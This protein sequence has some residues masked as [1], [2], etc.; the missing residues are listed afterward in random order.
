MAIKIGKIFQTGMLLQRGMPVKI[1]GKGTPGEKIRVMIQGQQSETLA[2]NSGGWT[3][4]LPPLEG[5]F[6]ETMILQGEDSR[7]EIEDIAVGEV[8]VA[9]GQS[10][11]EFWMRY[12]KFY[13]EMLPFCENSN[14]RFYDMPKLAYEGQESDFDY[15]NAGI[16]RKASRENLEYFSA[17]G[18]YFARK[19]EKELSVPIGIVGCNWGGTKSL[20]WMQEKHARVIQKEQTADFEARLKGQSYEEFYRAA[21]KNPMN[22][23]GNSTWKPFNDFILPRTPSKEEINEFLQQNGAQWDMEAAKPQ[24]APG[25][26]YRYMVQKLAPYTVRAILWYQG[27]S[28]DE[29]NGTQENY[30]IALDTIKKDWREAWGNPGLPFFIVQLPGFTSWFCCSNQNFSVI[31]R[32][33]QK[34][35]EEDANAFLCSISDAGEEFDIHP[36]NKKIVGERLAL[37]A[38]KYLFEKDI[39][40]DAPALKEARREG[41]KITLTFRHAKGGLYVDGTT[42]NA[43]IIAEKGHEIDYIFAIFDNSIILELPEGAYGRLKVRLACTLWYRVNLY[44][45]AGIPA[46]PFEVYC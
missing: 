30:K 22:D 26:L 23:T 20:T 24:D 39:L 8:F 18:Y 1:E 42:V 27:E 31:R 25:A 12:E 21:G 29:I 5:S 46:I 41:N 3:L 36:K 9:A 10:N 7:I 2:D 11:M 19:L 15:H 17:V 4:Y 28:D 35:A 45:Q 40:A 44:N 34:S 43:L 14:I 38:E 13:R 16:W 37:L 33:Q 32:C 6:R